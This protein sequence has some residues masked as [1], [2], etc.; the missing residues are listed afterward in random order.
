MDCCK[1]WFAFLSADLIR[2]CIDS[3]VNE[4]PACRDGLLSPLLH[5]H[6]QSNLREKIDRYFYQIVMEMDISALFDQFMIQFG[7]LNLDRE[8]FINIGQSFVR[9]STPD[10]IFYGKYITK[11]NDFAI[12]GNFVHMEPAKTLVDNNKSVDKP[13][14]AKRRK[15]NA[16]TQDVVSGTGASD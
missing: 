12:Y 13:I 3:S 8:N 7:W 11:E 14:K 4:C 10:A 1:T 6:N 5:F 16:I 2:R 9:F 15:K